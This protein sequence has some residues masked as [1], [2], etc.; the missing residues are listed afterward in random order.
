MSRLRIRDCRL[1]L[2][3]TGLGRLVLG[4][5]A[6]LPALLLAGSL[7]A[8]EGDYLQAYRDYQTAFETGNVT[9]ALT[10]GEAAWR[11][12]E[13]ELGD[14]P[15]T[16]VLAYNYARLAFPFAH[17]AE[18]AEHTYMRALNL[19]ARGI[20]DLDQTE[21]AIGLAE[22]RVILQK[23]ARTASSEL[24]R[25]LRDRLEADK[26]PSDVSAH[27]WKTLAG[28]HLRQS[29]WTTAVQYADIAA[30]EAGALQPPDRDVLIDALM[31]GAMARLTEPAISRSPGHLALASER[32][33]QAIALYPMQ[34]SIDSFD[35]RLAMAL[36]WRA[37]VA[38]MQRTGD[39]AGDHADLSRLTELVPMA[40]EGRPDNC[41][42]LQDVVQQTP[43]SFPST[44][45]E[46][47]SV[48]AV[49]FGLDLN[50]SGVERVVIL[51]EPQGSGFGAEVS[52][53]VKDWKLI[54]IVPEGCQRNWVTFAFFTQP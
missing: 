38:A 34:R 11:G 36:V 3:R 13:A 33:D 8:Q 4:R 46:K 31:L 44:A 10:H 20:G 54:T 27:A 5:I 52:R 1:A 2:V 43:I 35:R 28:E 14:H 18:L 37:S 26:A 23:D 40:P 51:G 7:S 45:L 6:L 24:T 49:L 22:L 32:L 15:T 21:V 12:A 42:E 47:R 16:A 53:V 50:Q 41:P 19:S 25:L 30:I 48:G 9:A 17:T 29:L 39:K